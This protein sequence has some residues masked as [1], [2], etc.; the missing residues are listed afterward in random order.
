MP[1]F[2]SYQKG[3]VSGELKYVYRGPLLPSNHVDD[4]CKERVGPTFQNKLNALSRHA[5]L[6]PVIYSNRHVEILLH[7][8]I[9]KRRNSHIK[10]QYLRKPQINL[11]LKRALTKTLE[12]ATENPARCM[13][14]HSASGSLILRKSLKNSSN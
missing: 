4:N 5:N 14:K 7:K 11:R 2:F 3:D 12:I 13:L 8:R 1:H 6:N 9:L 10:R